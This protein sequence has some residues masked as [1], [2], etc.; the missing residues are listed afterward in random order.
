MYARVH[1]GHFGRGIEMGSKIIRRGLV[2]ALAMGAFAAPAQADTAR[3]NVPIRMSDGKVMR[4]NLILPGEGKGT[5][6]SA[7]TI[8]GYNKDVSNP[9]GSNCPS[10]SALSAAGYVDITVDDR[11]TGASQ[12]KWEDWDHRTQRDYEEELDWIQAQPWSNG[13]VAMHGTS[14]LAL[15]SLLAAEADVRRVRV[16]K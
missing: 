4:A 10:S 12:G 8:T 11:G 1:R 14:Y 2:A 3:C 6:P 5:Y 15:T 9:S 13:Q 16:C 7:M